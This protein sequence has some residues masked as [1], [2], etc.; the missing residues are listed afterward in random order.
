MPDR[1]TQHPQA[2]GGEARP[3]V[4]LRNALISALALCALVAGPAAAQRADSARSAA[5]RD[6]VFESD[7]IIVTAT[8]T[9]RPVFVT[10]APV[11]VI[12]A[13]SMR[14]TQPNTI[15]E[16]LRGVPGVDVTGVGVQQPRPVIR[17]QRGQRI[18][19][20]QDGT[21]LNN[22][23]RQQDF[24]EVP[25][26]VDVA[27]IE[28]IEVVRG[29]AS[30]LYGSDAIGGVINIITR[31][32]AQEGVHGLIG[33]RFGQEESQHRGNASVLGRI[34]RVDFDVLASLRKAGDYRAPAGR[35]GDIELG[36]DAL[37]Q[38]TGVDDGSVAA[39]LGISIADG[40]TVSLRAERYQA[41]GAGFG[42]VDPAAYAPTQP[43]IDIRYPEQRFWKTTLAWS[44]VQ[45]G[46]P[47]ADR[48]D[49][50]G[51]LQDNERS[52]TFDLFQSF[53]PQ[54]PPGAG[55]TVGTH[56]FTDLRTWGGRL[57]AKKLVGS[58]LVLTYGGDAFRDR[59]V[60]TDSS[61][62]V[63]TGF[64]PPTRR[65][66]T[67]SLVPDATYRS[68][69]V[70]VQSEL[71]LGERA[72]LVAGGRAQTVRASAEPG[73]GM[74]VEA[75]LASSLVGAV[76]ALYR[77]S[78]HITLTGSVGRA[79]RAPNLI[80][81]FFEGPTP[82]GNGYQIRSPDL[83]PEKALSLDAGIRYRDGTIAFEAFAF[84]NR[85]TDG[86]RISP[87]GTRIGG[88][89]AYQNVNV[90]ALIFRGIELATEIHVAPGVTVD[91]A[92][93]RLSSED[94]LDPS[95]P[96]GDSFSSRLHANARYDAAGAWWLEYGVRHN[97]ERRDVAL[98]ENPVGDVLPA[99][100]THAIRG[101]ATLFRRGATTQRVTFGIENLTNRLYAEASNV[102]FFRPEPRRRLTIGLEASF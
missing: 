14:R 22:A 23:R 100:T 78:D 21:R 49:V 83:V 60:N 38:G 74:D 31:R 28:R 35:F 44:A 9:P 54:A 99:F 89:A 8:R 97:G 34:G 66:S 50:T 53:G 24:G 32:P 46:T 85:V 73:S 59:S 101:G 82:E 58:S 5:A 92:Y 40:H 29:P 2:I 48:V 11:A 67:T 12:G 64:G 13:E 63:V 27:A 87:T 20:L 75:K 45:L 55:V 88:L 98:T 36:E 84:R 69:G 3:R 102:S 57:E 70:F 18:L 79:F 10:P 30:V 26:L 42:F 81:W 95:N 86:I 52:L 93:T 17:G 51:W 77:I 68:A 94:A 25:A 72:T 7:A 65:V 39:R 91:G 61:L 1:S 56:N 33:Y 90:D 96:I 62:T 41:D 4:S 19:L 37:V 47:L 43:R 71:A 6:T 80:E 15:T 16:A 76:N